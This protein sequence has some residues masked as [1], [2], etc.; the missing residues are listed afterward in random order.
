VVFSLPLDL[1]ANWIF[2]STPFRTGRQYL[3]ARRRALLALS[4]APAWALSAAVLFSLWPW[5][6]AAGH[7][8]ALGFFG[9]VLAEFSFNGTQ[10]I[11]FACSYLPGKSNIHTT[12][13]LWMIVVFWGVIGAAVSERTALGSPVTA[14][15][16]LGGLGI[17]ALVCIVR[18]NRMAAS[19]DVELRFE[20]VPSD[21]LVGLHLS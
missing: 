16:L 17:A 13:W 14:A 1:G 11:P 21:R 4:V 12:F 6:L 5:K 9:I 18:N 15:A 8:A 7:L 20:E 3:N 10:K 2:R 19:S